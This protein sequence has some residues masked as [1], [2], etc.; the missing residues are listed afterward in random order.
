MQLHTALF[1]LKKGKEQV[2][3][4]W[5]T[6]LQTIYKKEALETLKEEGLFAEFSSTVTIGGDMY[7]IGG[8][9]QKE[10]GEKVDRELNRKHEEKKKECFEEKI[11]AA[12]DLNLFL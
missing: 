4:D 2:W 1:K 10:K 11:E 6:E 9:Y 5:C 7:V 8:I 12:T 3:K